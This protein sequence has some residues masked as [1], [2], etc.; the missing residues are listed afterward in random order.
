MYWSFAKVNNRLAEI[1]FSRRG[2]GVKIT[3]HY[4]VKSE[5]YKTKQEQRWIREDIEKF[6]FSF[7]KGVYKRKN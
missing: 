5:E 6:Q 7:R 3:G 2:K 4:Y 1:D